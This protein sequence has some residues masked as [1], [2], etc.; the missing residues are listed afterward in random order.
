MT[1]SESVAARWRFAVFLLLAPTQFACD[2]E[3]ATIST[4]PEAGKMDLSRPFGTAAP[5]AKKP[6]AA[7][8]QEGFVPKN[9]KLRN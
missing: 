1:I 9:P 6:K 5:E 3:N 2:R 4:P 8:A 7:K